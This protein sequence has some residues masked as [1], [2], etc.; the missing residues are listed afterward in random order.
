ML[1]K[2][3]KSFCHLRR[4]AFTLI[5]L[6]VVIAIIAILASLLLPALAKAKEKAR[7]IQ[8]LNNMKQV[9]VGWTLYANDNNGQMAHNWSLGSGAAPSGSWVTGNVQWFPSITNGNDVVAGSLYPYVSSLSVYRCPDAYV[10]N[11]VIPIRTVSI[12]NRMGG[13]DPN[14]SSIYGVWDS[15]SVLGPNYLPYHRM[16]DI[17][18]PEP[19]QAAVCVDES[20]ITVDDGMYCITW[21]YWQNSPGTRHS[22]GMTLS[23]ADGHVERWRW[24]GLNAELGYN[25]NPS[26]AAQTDDFQKLLAAI[27]LP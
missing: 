6:L 23:F 9:T 15:S 12:N 5:E 21:T 25:A 11:G 27:A 16:A 17:A 13:S 24:K 26:G 2:Q 19:S 20:E 4:N 3:G 1:S 22:N 7:V 10:Y 14:D 8:C 18:R